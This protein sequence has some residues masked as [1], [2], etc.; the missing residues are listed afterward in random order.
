[1]NRDQPYSIVITPVGGTLMLVAVCKDHKVSFIL[2]G[3]FIYSNMD[4]YVYKQRRNWVVDN[5]SRQ[6]AR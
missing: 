1:M 2:I 5:I 3:K 6:E 4:K